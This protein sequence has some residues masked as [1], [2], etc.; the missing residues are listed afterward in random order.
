[1]VLR[2]IV[3]SF[4]LASASPRRKDLLASIGLVPSRIVPANAD[5]TPIKNEKP[6]LYARRIAALKAACVATSCPGEVVLAADTVVACGARILPKAED[7]KTARACLK[8]LSGKRHR[9]Y[10]AVVVQR[11]TKILS[12]TVMTVV[13]FTRLS[14]ADIEHYIV[15][16]EWN[17]KAGG[18]AIQGLAQ[19]FIP[20]I[21]GSHSNVVGLPLRE[22]KILLE[23][24]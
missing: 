16:G 15:S 10:T 17:G 5:E 9:V 19:Q 11:D 23:A 21:N 13:Q 22:T 18:Y 12:K 2:G 3:Q 20:R 6:H 1:M 24:I 8:L 4:I 7:E 14:D